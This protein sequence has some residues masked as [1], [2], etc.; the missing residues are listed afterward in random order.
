MCRLQTPVLVGNTVLN[1]SLDS[2]ARA[3]YNRLPPCFSLYLILC[4]TFNR[5][6]YYNARTEWKSAD[7]S[8]SV[9]PTLKRS[10]RAD[11]V[12]HRESD[13]KPPV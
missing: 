13:V 3:D 1:L 5:N 12:G 2:S 10:R 9:L 8:T 11:G 7:S 6:D 4:A